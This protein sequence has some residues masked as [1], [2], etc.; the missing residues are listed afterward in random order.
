MGF[1]E[2]KDGRGWLDL[3]LSSEGI[4]HRL[5][6][7]S[8]KFLGLALRCCA[9]T[10]ETKELLIVVAFV[11]EVGAAFGQLLVA[12]VEWLTVTSEIFNGILHIN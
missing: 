10:R 7:S 5:L 4:Q 8:R 1:E 6:E 2:R 9:C 12:P 11:G 3:C